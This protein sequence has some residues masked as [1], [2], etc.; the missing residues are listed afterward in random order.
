MSKM[1]R[2][3]TLEQLG[4][5]S[6]SSVEHNL[7]YLYGL[8]GEL[9]IISATLGLMYSNNTYTTAS[10]VG[11]IK[12]NDYE[13]KIGFGTAIT[14]A[15]SKVFSGFRIQFLKGDNPEQYEIN[16]KFFLSIANLLKDLHWF[17]NGTSYCHYLR[18][19]FQAPYGAQALTGYT[20]VKNENPG[21]TIND[22]GSLVSIYIT[23]EYGID[24]TPGSFSFGVGEFLFPR[25]S[26]NYNDLD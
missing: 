25:Y 22:S 8:N 20:L 7:L 19:A 18:T 5:A 3:I 14:V 12:A 1:V 2:G 11:T 17:Y 6:E 15:A 13:L 10:N 16:R 4:G 26:A 21:V 23:F 24:T 9:T